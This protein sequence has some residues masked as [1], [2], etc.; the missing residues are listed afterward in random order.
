MDYRISDVCTVFLGTQKQK[1]I[2]QD[3]QFIL[4][5]QSAVRNG[6][7]DPD[8]VRRGDHE[9]INPDLILKEGDVLLTTKGDKTRGRVVSISKNII[10]NSEGLPSI[11]LSG[12]VVL[13][14][15]GLV[16]S[17]Y[18]SYFLLHPD[19]KAILEHSARGILPLSSYDL[20]VLKNILI[21]VPS[22]EKQ[23]ETVRKVGPFLE[24][25][26]FLEYEKE[27]F[28]KL[29]FSSIFHSF[30]EVNYETKYK[31]L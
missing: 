23:R 21:P 13:R 4:I 31:D 25:T 24:L 29:A 12:I 3:G 2:K 7:I 14:P 27:N 19:V 20:S 28:L 9:K 8:K 16:I 30:K 22:I 5:G 26:C 17:E 10:E 15:N 18:L 6:F 1:T 11:T